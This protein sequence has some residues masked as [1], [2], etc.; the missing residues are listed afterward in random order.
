M[1][2]RLPIGIQSFEKLR[3]GGYAYV[4]KTGLIWELADS[5]SACFLSR[6]RRFGKSLIVSTL[7]AYFSGRRELFEGLAIEGLEKRWEEFPVI[8]ID[9]SRGSYGIDGNFEMTIDAILGE[10]EDAYG[11]SANSK[12]ASQRLDHLI[13]ELRAKTSKKVVVLIDEYD[14]PI[15]DAL[16]KPHEDAN[17]EKLRDLYSPLKAC[18]EHLRFVFLTG[19]TKVSHVNIFSGLNQL[20]DISLSDR[21]ATICGITEDEVLGCFSSEVESLAESNHLK[22]ESCMIELRRRYDGYSFSKS[23]KQVYN[24]FCLLRSLDSGEFGSYWMESGTPSMLVKRLQNQVVKINDIMQDG[25]EVG[26]DFFA[27]YDPESSDIAPLLYQTGYLTIKGYDSENRLYSLG[28]PNSEVSEGLMGRLLPK[29]L[30]SDSHLDSAVAIERLRKALLHGNAHDIVSIVSSCVSGIPTIM[31]ESCENYYESIVHVLFRAT[32]F[33]VVG[34]MQSSAGR[35]DIVLQ[36]S[37]FV[38]IFELKMDRGSDDVDGL[39]DAA[40]RQIGEKGYAKPFEASGKAVHKVA[41][42]FSSAKKGLVGWKEEAV[43]K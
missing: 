26:T 33:E 6:P 5:F 16:Y 42:V 18:D 29:F 34:Q 25:F 30:S 31:R 3:Q 36:T 37:R 20:A 11:I 41:L 9:F 23:C 15:L 10:Y 12:G 19:I 38:W 22:F 1:R 17:R 14:K 27:D 8:R 21:F 35:A 7:E 32:G 13:R 40:L 2:R 28:F 39:C 4:D 24:P 43:Q